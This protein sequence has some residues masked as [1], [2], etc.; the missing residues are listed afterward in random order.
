MGFHL[1]DI[2]EKAKLFREKT[3]QWLPGRGLVEGLTTK[4]HGEFFEVMELF[5]I[6]FVTVVTGVYSFVKNHRITH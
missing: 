1:Y 3:N 2:V 4:R 6:L 5:Y